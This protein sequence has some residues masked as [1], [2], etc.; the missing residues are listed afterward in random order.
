MQ[1]P[2]PPQEEYSLLLLLSQ[3]R[4]KDVAFVLGH[5]PGSHE[6]IKQSLNHL[7]NAGCIHIFE[8]HN[9]DPGS[10]MIKVLELGYQVLL[11]SEYRLEQQRQDS[12]EKAAEKRA[13][14]KFHLLDALIGAV[15]SAIVVE[16]V[17]LIF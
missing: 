16:V 3:N 7:Q 4:N 17:R 15:I 11:S 5:Y 10:R 14:R 6:Q 1:I 2:Q 8:S 12:A 13:D 9:G